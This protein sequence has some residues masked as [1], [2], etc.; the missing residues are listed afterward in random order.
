MEEILRWGRPEMSENPRSEAERET[1]LRMVAEM[2]RAAEAAGFRPVAGI[3][4]WEAVGFRREVGAVDFRL[5]A[6]SRFHPEEVAAVF[7]LAAEAV[8]HSAAGVF[9]PEEVAEAR[10]P[11]E[12]EGAA[13]HRHRAAAEGAVGE[14]EEEEEGVAEA[15]GL[16]PT[17]RRRPNPQLPRSEQTRRDRTPSGRPPR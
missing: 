2:N 7:H 14:E 17:S 10:L 12:E 11:M 8:I 9:L 4:P 6:E 16:D 15:P 13:L 5:E 1:H 3:L